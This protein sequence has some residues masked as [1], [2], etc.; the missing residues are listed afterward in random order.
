MLDGKTT[1]PHG[2]TG[3]IG[4]QLENYPIC[5]F[6]AIE[7]EMLH[8]SDKTKD[9]LRCDQKYLCKIVKAVETGHVSEL[10]ANLHPRKWSI[11]NGL[12]LPIE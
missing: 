7:T 11:L 6:D 12:P 3:D 9:H 5:D 4:R 10:L 2:Y 8:L 1:D